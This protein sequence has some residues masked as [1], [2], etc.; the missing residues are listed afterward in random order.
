[1]YYSLHFEQCPRTFHAA[2]VRKKLRFQSFSFHSKKHKANGHPRVRG[3]YPNVDLKFMMFGNITFLMNKINEGGF[4]LAAVDSNFDSGLFR[5]T[6]KMEFARL[7]DGISRLG[8]LGKDVIF[9]IFPRL[10]NRLVE[11]RDK[12]SK[13]QALAPFSKLLKC[14][15][16]LKET[17]RL[18][19]ESHSSKSGGLKSILFYYIKMM[20]SFSYF[21]TTYNVFRSWREKVVARVSTQ[22]QSTMASVW[23]L[24]LSSQRAGDVNLSA[25]QSQKRTTACDFAVAEPNDTP[26]VSGLADLA[27]GEDYQRASPIETLCPSFS[28]PY[29]SLASPTL[30]G[31][32]SPS[33]FQGPPHWLVSPSSVGHSCIRVLRTLRLRTPFKWRPKGVLRPEVSSLV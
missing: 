15:A 28:L 30:R 8:S 16:C 24:L 23:S 20:R 6:R 2:K 33:V 4:G 29:A 25:V 26:A 18:S 9:H 27:S 19:L 21:P 32:L 11:I 7:G 12:A 31:A 1:M 17:R 3:L 10:S 5:K 22:R 14:R 13:D